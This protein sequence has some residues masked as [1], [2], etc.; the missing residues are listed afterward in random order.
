MNDPIILLS[1]PSTTHKTCFPLV[2][3][4]MYSVNQE[5]ISGQRPEE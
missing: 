5:Y 1:D 3:P 2:I 4:K